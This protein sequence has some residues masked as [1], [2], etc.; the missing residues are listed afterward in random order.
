VGRQIYALGLSAKASEFSGIPVA[1]IKTILFALSGLLS[2]A[3]GVIYTA[4]FSSSRASNGLGLELDVI[5]MVLLGGVSIFGGRGR[6]TGVL[7]GMILVATVRKALALADVPNEV[8]DAVIGALLIFAVLG[9]N[10]AGMVKE[11]W[12]ASMRAKAA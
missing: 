10:L 5:T 6:L 3:A 2:A 11:R 7:L 1:R 9:P 12:R 4:R 8:H